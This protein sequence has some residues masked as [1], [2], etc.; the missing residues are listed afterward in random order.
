MEKYAIKLGIK[1][2]HIEFLPLIFFYRTISSKKKLG[3]AF[4][5]EER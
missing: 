5:L 3:D 2:D 4:S 1:K